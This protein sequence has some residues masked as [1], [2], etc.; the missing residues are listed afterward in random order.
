VAQVWCRTCSASDW[1]TRR[2]AAER[3]ARAERRR[4]AKIRAIAE[5]PLLI[6][7]LELG[8]LRG[9]EEANPTSV[10]ARKIATTLTPD[11]GRKLAPASHLKRPSRLDCTPRW[12]KQNAQNGPKRGLVE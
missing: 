11:P 10:V 7:E 12:L 2:F 5:R 4:G 8:A 1:I 6:V 9:R 3:L